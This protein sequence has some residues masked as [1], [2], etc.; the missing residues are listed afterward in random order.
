M[1]KYQLNCA[2]G[3]SFEG[4][5]TNSVTFDEHIE[6][7]H[8]TCPHCDSTD[9]TKALMAPNIA[10]RSNKTDKEPVNLT[11]SKAAEVREMI[12]AVHKHLNTNAEYVG[13][14]FA[15]E[16]RKIHGDEADKR[17]I[18]GEATQEESRDLLEDGILIIPVPR[19]PDD[20]N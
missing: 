3:H 17:E 6:L 19:L 9:V 16:V 5:F 8:I 13:P 10:T 1:I 12:R 20:H 15:E 18:W 7:G 2:S 11:N 4:W 14:Q